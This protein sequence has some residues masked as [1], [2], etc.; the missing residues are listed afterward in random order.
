MSEASSSDVRLANG[1]FAKG[2]GP[3][4]LR[5][6][7]EFDGPNVAKSE[8]G[9]FLVRFSA[10]FARLTTTSAGEKHVAPGC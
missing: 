9:R 5:S 1:H 2:R 4:R 6:A 3:G 7:P 10:V 8:A